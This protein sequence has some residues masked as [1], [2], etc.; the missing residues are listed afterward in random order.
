M[1]K[2]QGAPMFNASEMV[3][4]SSMATPWLSIGLR[5]KRVGRHLAVRSGL[6]H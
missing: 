3:L 4:A 1:L 6:R 5:A 2:G